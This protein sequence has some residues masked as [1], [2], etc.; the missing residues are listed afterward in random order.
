MRD[1]VS[2]YGA[3]LAIVLFGGSLLAGFYAIIDWIITIV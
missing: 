3:L 2:E 1:Y